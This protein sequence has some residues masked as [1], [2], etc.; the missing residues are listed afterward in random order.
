MVLQ[1]L[2]Q[3]IFIF[4]SI[5]PLQALNK[6]DKITNSYHLDA[7]FQGCVSNHGGSLL[8]RPFLEV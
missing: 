8:L 6:R 2:L 1:G 4:S 3:S 7:H 5:A